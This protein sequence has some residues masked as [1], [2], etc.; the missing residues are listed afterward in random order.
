MKKL[1]KLLLGLLI[2]SVGSLAVFLV[3]D[4]LTLDRKAPEVACSQ[5]TM[6]VSVSV[7]EEE[8][9]HGV[10]ALDDR[11]GDLTADL[12]VESLS[13]MGRDHTRTVTYAVMDLEGNVGRAERTIHYTDYQPPRLQMNAPLRVGDREEMYLLLDSLRAGSVLD[14]D[15]SSKLKYD[16]IDGG[17]ISGA[18]FYS[19][20][21]R[22]NDSTGNSLIVPTQLELY[23]KRDE[24]IQVQ[25]KEYITYLHVN[26]LFDPD[27]YYLSASQSGRMSCESNVDTSVPGV[28]HVHYLVENQA[29]GDY[30]KS[31]LIVVV[32]E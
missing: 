4:H 24:T 17:L 5:E 18:G 16:F 21:F 27:S 26:D 11:D 9:L 29:S 1:K 25:L 28:Y 8:L 32:E 3:V 15:L 22:V 13:A 6:D 2:V 19:V 12:V 14:G 20:Q 30:G 7:T 31:T 23:N 10:T